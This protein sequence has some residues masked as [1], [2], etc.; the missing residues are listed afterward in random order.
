LSISQDYKTRVELRSLVK[1]C[2]MVTRPKLADLER[3]RLE[4]KR[5]RYIRI[6]VCMAILVVAVLVLG[7]L[8]KLS[9]LIPNA[10]FIGSL[11]YMWF[12][13]R[14]TDALRGTV[15]AEI[16]SDIMSHL[17]W[18][19][20]LKFK[21]SD[22]FDKLDMYGVFP[23]WQHRRYEDKITGKISGVFFTANEVQLIDN[24]DDGQLHYD[25]FVI[26][27]PCAKTF[28]AMTLIRS[29]HSILNFNQKKFGISRELNLLVHNLKNY[30]MCI[31]LM[32]LKHNIFYLPIRSK[33]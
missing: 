21:N 27:V 13:S 1:H 19:H 16:V 28:S 17:G 22:D 12:L 14:D 24:R 6:S 25:L 31:L 10:L 11:V 30:S 15:K 3:R 26:K 23:K 7:K 2:D 33:R 29:K 18:A 20:T 8:T 5:Q 4:T 9:H 32:E